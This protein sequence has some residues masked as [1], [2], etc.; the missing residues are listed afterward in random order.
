MISAEFLRKHCYS[1][2]YNSHMEKKKR[3]SKY[4]SKMLESI[5]NP[6]SFNRIKDF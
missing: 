4:R 1:Y 6:R 3:N 2:I 5:R